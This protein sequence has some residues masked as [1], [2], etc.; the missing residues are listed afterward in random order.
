ME[1]SQKYTVKEIKELELLYTG[2]Y[3]I[4]RVDNYPN[5]YKVH[6][7]CTRNPKVRFKAHSRKSPSLPV[8]LFETISLLEAAEKERE[9]KRDTGIHDHTDYIN[10]LKRV[11]VS[12]S[13]KVRRKA[14]A[15]TD[16][17]AFQERKVAN[18][19]Y[20][21]RTLNTHYAAFQER[22]VAKM[23]FKANASHLQRRV[24]SIS[25]EGIRKEYSGME[26]AA[27]QLTLKTGI[28]F[29]SAGIST[30][31]SPKRPDCKTYKGYTFEYL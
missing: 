24:V 3:F 19:D 25:P 23:D 13:K 7:G 28:K 31:C 10:D 30:V 27:R 12:R 11:I 20:K 6:I 26:E 2:P 1:L 5:K 4:Y 21:A 14:V 9:I 17:K 29:Y 16:Y 18:T 22:R 15:N 8:V